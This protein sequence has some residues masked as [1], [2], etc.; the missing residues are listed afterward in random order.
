MTLK[1]NNVNFGT[2]QVFRKALHHLK[3]DVAFGS[4]AAI[5]CVGFKDTERNTLVEDA[6]PLY[7]VASER[8]V[9]N[10]MVVCFTI[11]LNLIA[12]GE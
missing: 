3:D 11:V 8:H 2:L 4:M 1:Y 6:E 9:K 7:V 12:L 10:L 5:N